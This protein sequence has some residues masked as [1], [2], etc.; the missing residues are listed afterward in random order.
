[1]IG[2]EQQRIIDRLNTLRKE[3]ELLESHK[4]IYGDDKEFG[5]ITEKQYYE[6][7]ERIVAEL[8]ALEDELGVE[9]KPESTINQKLRELRKEFD[10]FGIMLCAF[11]KK[12][13]EELYNLKIQE[14]IDEVQDEYV[15]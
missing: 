11:S 15:Q 6:T 13:D 5:L 7:G 9:R 1:M 8:E 14:T 3:V 4:L 12:L 10:H 2:Q